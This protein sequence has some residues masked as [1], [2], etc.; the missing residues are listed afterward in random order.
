MVKVAIRGNAARRIVHD[1]PTRIG[2]QA[3]SNP[4][5][6]SRARLVSVRALAK[7]RQRY[8]GEIVLAGRVDEVLGY[9]EG[10]D[11]GIYAF[12]IDINVVSGCRAFI[13]YSFLDSEQTE[14]ILLR[15]YVCGNLETGHLEHLL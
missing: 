8:S 7:F 2:N 4:V 11:G 15:C 14:N 13:T 9:I 3:S 6:K 10:I 1:L 12:Q 5:G